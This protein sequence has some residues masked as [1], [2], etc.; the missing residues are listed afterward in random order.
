LQNQKNSLIKYQGDIKKLSWKD[1]QK[2]DGKKSN[3][4]EAISE[5][6]VS[7]RVVE[8]G[9]GLFISLVPSIINF[10]CEAYG[11][12][13]SHNEFCWVKEI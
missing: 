11:G 13:F 3:L 1:D 10:M 5:Q 8:S 4:L 7:K 2:Y 9:M 12:T 6:N